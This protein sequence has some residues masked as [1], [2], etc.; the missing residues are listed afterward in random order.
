VKKAK[1]EMKL[2]DECLIVV[3]LIF[4]CTNCV[5]SKE[6]ND[7]KVELTKVE[8]YKEE[9]TEVNADK[10]M[11]AMAK[12]IVDIVKAYYIEPLIQF[13]IHA[14]TGLPNTTEEQIEHFFNAWH[15]DTVTDSHPVLIRK[16]ENPCIDCSVLLERSALIFI[17]ILHV[18]DFIVSA[19]TTN[20]FTTDL[21]YV[22]FIERTPGGSP[23]SEWNYNVDGFK[24][25]IQHV[26]YQ[27]VAPYIDIIYKE[28]GT[29][30]LWTITWF[31]PC[32]KVT[33]KRLNEFDMNALEWKKKLK[34]GEKFKDMKNCML[35]VPTNMPNGFEDLEQL[36]SQGKLMQFVA[37]RLNFG[38]NYI[39]DCHSCDIFIAISWDV[40]KNLAYSA[41]TALFTMD[42]LVFA[43]SEAEC[44]TSYEK[45]LLPFDE[46]TWY[47]LTATF[48]FAFG[49][50]FVVSRLSKRWQDIVYGEGVRVP[51]LNVLGTFFG[52][53]Q[54]HLPTTFFARAILI[55]FI[56][57]CLIFR[58]AYQG[59]FYELMTT[60]MRKPQPKTFN[61]LIERN[62]TIVGVKSFFV[63]LAHQH[64]INV[65]SK[66][67]ISCTDSTE[68]DVDCHINKINYR[69]VEGDFK[70]TDDYNYESMCDIIR[71][72]SA[73]V[74]YLFTL[75]EIENFKAECHFEPPILEEVMYESALG[76]FMPLNHYLFSFI[77]NAAQRFVEAGIIQWWY[78]FSKFVEY[79]GSFVDPE[80][81]EPHVLTLR[82]LSFGFI[83][84]L[85][86]CGFAFVV[87][88]C[89]VITGLIQ[90][91]VYP[92][93]VT[94]EGSNR[95][96]IE[97]MV[98]PG[99]IEETEVAGLS[100]W[101]DKLVVE[102]D[103]VAEVV[104][105]MEKLRFHEEAEVHVEEI[106]KISQV[107]DATGQE[108][109]AT[110]EVYTASVAEV[111]TDEVQEIAP[112]QPSQ[113]DDEVFLKNSEYL[114]DHKSCVSAGPDNDLTVIDLN[115]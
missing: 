52:I 10:P 104:V 62:Y 23:I 90:A 71:D 28:D 111:S 101:D 106:T 18:G 112:A 17:D 30:S 89:E 78:E 76:V 24:P 47:L 16:L 43:I 38:T 66:Y 60:D 4:H 86:A 84:W 97:E 64:Q 49:A 94:E 20:R 45:I 87:F 91:K 92:F 79:H 11:Q 53:A 63:Y 75:N 5:S 114:F 85:I 37:E 65:F 99:S 3:L 59:V 57:F 15:N 72:S 7:K 13:D 46:L 35:D 22:L 56:G 42:R 8:P 68:I 70:F 61:D 51:A 74:A 105:V 55:L 102:E 32:G 21:R 31:E 29:L 9:P 67:N 39:S 34:F 88:L 26:S 40:D 44:Y 103:R 1:E 113:D 25:F 82:V 58:T 95:M 80:V 110:A 93:R 33:F 81:K 36:T 107:G 73:K 115:D 54:T 100:F 69:V 19:Y 27:S 98:E 96:H 6:I 48:G 41:A 83:I 2:F 77:E 12:G 108:A 109:V 50:I 14:Y